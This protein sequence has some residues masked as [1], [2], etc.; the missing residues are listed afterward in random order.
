MNLT[1]K[2]I[3]IAYGKKEIVRDIDIELPTGKIVT[4]AGKNGCGKSSIIKTLTKTAP[5]QKG[6][7]F[8]DGKDIGDFQRRDLAKKMAILPQTATAP[9]DIDVQTLI[10]YGRF[11]YKKF[12]HSYSKEDEEIIE[13]TIQL[14]QLDELRFQKIVTL[15]GGE[16]QR[17]RIAM[18]LCQRPE[19]L[20]LDEPTTYLDI[21]YQI[22]ILDLIKRINREFGI[23]ILMVLHELNFA[24]RYSDI[25]Y[26]IDDKEIFAS[27]KPEQIICPENLGQVFGVDTEL[28]QHNPTGKPYFIPLGLTAKNNH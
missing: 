11:P 7:I 22:E 25:I 23:S 6:E 18:A 1:F 10:S 5:M 2:Q 20:I 4:L 16:R 3:S 8:I 12:G 9:L 13:Q 27:G 19:I 14:T 28:W 15:S 26:L 24:A 21:A 17:V